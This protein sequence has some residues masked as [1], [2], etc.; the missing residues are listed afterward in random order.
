[1]IRSIQK[2]TLNTTSKLNLIIASMMMKQPAILPASQ[3]PQDSMMENFDEI[4]H[5]TDDIQGN[6]T[7]QEYLETTE[8][9]LSTGP[10]MPIEDAHL[11]ELS[12]HQELNCHNELNSS[13]EIN[14]IVEDTFSVEHNHNQELNSG[15]E[16]ECHTTAFEEETPGDQE[17]HDE[18]HG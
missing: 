13:E 14:S 7:F 5:Q 6:E 8:A 3:Q 18:M 16:Y 4:E 17:N 11:D 1:M 2:F 12:L 9:Q 10:T 15:Q